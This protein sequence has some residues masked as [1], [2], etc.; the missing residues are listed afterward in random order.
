MMRE[1]HATPRDAAAREKDAV[2]AVVR[3]ALLA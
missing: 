1:E 3:S 2:L